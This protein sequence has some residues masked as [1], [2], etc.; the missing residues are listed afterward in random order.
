MLNVTS[1]FGYNIS[2]KLAA[3][4][5]GEYRTSV[6][7]NFNNPGYLDLGVGL[8]YTPMKNMIIV[9]HPL[10]YNFIFAEN[11]SKFTPSLGCKIVGDY[12]TEIV[13][14][15]NW[16]TNLTGFYS[17]KNNTPSLHNGTWTN[18]LGFNVW[19]GVGVG[20]EFAL[21]MSDQEVLDEIQNYYTVGLSYKL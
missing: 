8:T 9:F 1:L 12:N 17:Y 6:I 14:G 15:I 2:K 3:S 13:K 20:L 19:K 16:R 5:L 10:N 18:W 4:T 11:D 7:K 21:R